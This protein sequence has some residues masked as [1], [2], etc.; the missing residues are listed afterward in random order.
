V[1]GTAIIA[2]TVA[3]A[4]PLPQVS[5]EAERRIGSGPKVPAHMRAPGFEGG[6]G[7]EV[8]GRWS[9]RFP[10]K[11]YAFEVRDASG[12]NRDVPLLGMPADDDWILYAA[13]NDRT[14]IRNAVAYD[15]A[16]WMGRYAARTRFVELRV[17][18][19][20]RGVY[21]L[22]ERLK[23]HERRVGGDFLLEL[24]SRR[25]VRRKG[26]SFRTPLTR[27]PIVWEDPERGELSR[28]QA[29]RVRRQVARA[30]RA[31]YRGG[32]GAWRRH[33]HAPS[34]IDFLLINELF[35]NEDGLHA[36]TFM[37][38]SPGRAIRLGPVWDFDVS[39]G[40][41]TH[42]PSR[43]LRGWMLANRPWAER[44]YRDRIFAREMAGRWHQL[45][46][47][48]LRTRLLH[49]VDLHAARL[50]DAARRDSARWPAGGD[51]PR[52]SRQAHV[53]ELRRWLVRRIAWLDENLPRLG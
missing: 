20:Y 45:R 29:M 48:G 35:K 21:L 38:T 40:Q 30:E 52:G 31:L 44:L 13:Y 16:R 10:K 9:R 27:R 39:A 15:T 8:R 17:N 43:F 24:T 23:L 36:S 18:G 25:Q 19:D 42:G 47:A 28:R 22:M 49:Q 51:R 46:R 37:S 4:Q 34:T 12:D 5:V 26:P 32:E 2:L 53:R 11:S 41:S 7:I 6:I 50:S 3:A 14:L 33:V 1:L